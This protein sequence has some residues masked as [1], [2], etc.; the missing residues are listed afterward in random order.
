M[1]S[2]IQDVQ[3]YPTTPSNTYRVNIGGA[4]HGPYPVEHVRELARTQE[5]SPT[6][7]V[8][9]AGQAWVP[10]TSAPASSRTSR[11]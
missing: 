4:E 9:Y 11:T 2:P 5:L 1:T 7:A 10:A 6:D 3:P 8:S